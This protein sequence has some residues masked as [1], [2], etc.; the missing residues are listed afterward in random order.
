MTVHTG[1]RRYFLPQQNVTRRPAVAAGTPAIAAEVPSRREEKRRSAACLCWASSLSRAVVRVPPTTTP[2]P[3]R[4]PCKESRRTLLCILEGD[5]VLPSVEMVLLETD[6]QP[7]KCQDGGGEHLE[8]IRRQARA[9]RD[10]GG[11]FSQTL[12]GSGP[13]HIVHA[14]PAPHRRSLR[15]L[16]LSTGLRR[17]P[18]SLLRRR[19][20]KLRFGQA[21]AMARALV[22]SRPPSPVLRGLSQPGSPGP[23]PPKPE[24]RPE[25][26]PSLLLGQ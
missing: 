7:G 17:V 9:R 8:E 16:S 18:L 23:P 13:A 26:T 19:K 5:G 12:P 20:G 1:G 10:C 22:G 3:G 14:D 6:R 2:I 21:S 24:P 15:A 25:E 11:T 4:M